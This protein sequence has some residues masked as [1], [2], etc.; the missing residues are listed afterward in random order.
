MVQ[1]PVSP[2]CSERQFLCGPGGNLSEAPLYGIDGRWTT[3]RPT[4]LYSAAGRYET[5]ETWNTDPVGPG[6]DTYEPS[7]KHPQEVGK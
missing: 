1:V 5:L 2:V 7:F 6:L 4:A 3:P